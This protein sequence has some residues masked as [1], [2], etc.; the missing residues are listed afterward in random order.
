MIN[1]KT[2][3]APKRIETP[4]LEGLRVMVED[5]KFDKALRI[6]NK[7]VQDSGLLREL[8]DRE[9]YEKP[10]MARKR[11]KAIAKKRARKQLEESNAKVFGKRLY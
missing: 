8:K 10:S 3:F 7:K 6:F 5:G 1:K 4:K 11:T 2:R 9:F